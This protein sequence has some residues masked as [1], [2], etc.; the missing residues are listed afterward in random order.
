AL[1]EL[2]LGGEVVHRDAQHLGIR[3]GELP[4]L[5]AEGRH[6]TR[7]AA[8]ERLRVERKHHCAAAE[9]GEL[10]GLAVGRLC[11]ERRRGIAGCGALGEGGGREEQRSE[12]EGSHGGHQRLLRWAPEVASITVPVIALD[13]AE[14]RNA[15][16]SAT[17]STVVS[18]RV[19][20]ARS[21]LSR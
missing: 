4:R 19:A 15:I 12:H 3:V 17:S 5:V 21:S 14:Q 9:V 6:L 20:V 7:S 11:A 16:T 1:G 18:L 10:E 2:L 8:G 13:R